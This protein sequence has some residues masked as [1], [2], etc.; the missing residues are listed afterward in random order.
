MLC[1]KVNA[2]LT[3]SDSLIRKVL[4]TSP[5]LMGDNV[6]IQ[7]LESVM[8]KPTVFRVIMKHWSIVGARYYYAINDSTDL[9]MILKFQRKLAMPAT[10]GNCISIE[11][12]KKVV[13]SHISVQICTTLQSEIINEYREFNKVLFCN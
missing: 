8:I 12:F 11:E 3:P 7:M 6:T 10:K 2:Q 13:V 1:H 9:I 5:F 4:L